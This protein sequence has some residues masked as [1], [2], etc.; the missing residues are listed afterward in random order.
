MSKD[1]IGTLVIVVLK[2]KNLNDKY[3]WKQD[4]F[5]QV[6]LN[7]DKK[8]TRVDVKGG[9][10]P[11]WDEEIRMPIMRDTHEKY[12][13]LQVSCWAKEPR[14][15]VSV[16]AGIVDLTQTLKTGEFDDWV[17]LELDGVER[18]EIYLEMTF[19]ANA[20]A[21]T[22]QGLAPPKSNNNLQRRPSKLSPAERL[23]RPRPAQAEVLPL[24]NQ[25]HHGRHPSQTPPSS[26]QPSPSPPRHGRESSLP[27]VPDQ[28]PS[29]PVPGALTPGRPRPQQGGTAPA[30]G[31]NLAAPG[32]TPHVPSILRPRNP[33]SSPTPIPG[34]RVEYSGVVPAPETEREVE[35][36]SPPRGGYTPVVPSADS[37][38]RWDSDNGSAPSTF[39]FPV[40]NIAG[41]SITSTPPY[42]PPPTTYTPPSGPSTP[43]PTLNN[44]P[45]S[46]PPQTHTPPAPYTPQPQPPQAQTSQSSYGQPPFGPHP[47]QSQTQYP[48]QNQASY[49]PQNQA[50]YHPPPPAFQ[51][52][53]YQPPASSFTPPIPG[54]YPG[55]PSNSTGQNLPDPYLL[56][57]YQ[58]PLPLPPGAEPR[59]RATSH[60]HT[61]TQSGGQQP[62]PRRRSPSP[63]KYSQNKPAPALPVNPDNARIQALRQVE[64]EAE[65]RRAQEKRDRELALQQQ[66]E[67]ENN[68]RIEA[69]RKVEEEAARRRAQEKRDREL[70]LQQQAEAENTR[71][72]QEERDLEL[73]RQLDRELNLG[74]ASG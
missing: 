13:K 29:P 70:A 38:F 22:G 2:A 56:K 9:Q 27:P 34:P 28:S 63:P 18:G 45:P 15:E 66:A 62:P 46:Y 52:A 40:P 36:G 31:N 37:P 12:R 32:L 69:L 8:Q 10:S 26:K 74:V 42:V 47:P 44:H 60:S 3:F 24:V 49:P 55:S 41:T 35:S 1:E 20:R 19:Y 30:N 65:R 68:A 73:A 64:E 71:K 33:K 5:A 7:G 25:Q 4:V 61:R 6:S 14:K 51:Q 67:A 72:S 50:S 48:T 39:S 16:G 43:A 54:A 21:P 58:S 17:N 57:R 53:P 11:E 23:S 59:Q